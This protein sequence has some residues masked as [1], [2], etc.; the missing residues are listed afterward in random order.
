MPAGMNNL[1]TNFDQT[2]TFDKIA[3]IPSD[4]F[5]FTG[6]FG[7]IPFGD[8]LYREAGQPAAAARKAVSDHLP[9]W[10]EFRVTE[11]EHHLDQ[12]INT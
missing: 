1:G 6:T 2:K 8:V 9:L 11:L 5:E 12:I 7:A 3:W 10:A 4:E